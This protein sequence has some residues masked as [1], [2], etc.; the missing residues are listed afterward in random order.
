[1]RR[2]LIVLMLLMCVRGIALSDDSRIGVVTLNTANANVSFSNTNEYEWR[3]ES[4]VNA[5]FSTNYHQD[6][7]TSQTTITITNDKLCTL[8]FEYG[9][10]SEYYY[11]YLVITLDGAIIV[12]KSG[13]VIDSYSGVLSAGTHDLEL[14]YVKDVN[15]YDNNDL[16]Y[17]TDLKIDNDLKDLSGVFWS[18]DESEG[19]L[20]ISG[21]GEM[22]DYPLW[23]DE[24]QP[25]ATYASQI[26][27]IVIGEGITRIGKCCFNGYSNVESV[28]LPST[29]LSIGF[30]A[31]KECGIK[32]ITIPSSVSEIDDEAFTYCTDMTDIYISGSFIQFG[33]RAF[34]R[35]Y[36]LNVHIED[37]S[38]WCNLSFSDAEANP[39][40]TVRSKKL[41]TNYTPKLY[42]NETVVSDLQ[43]PSS[44]TEI[45]DFTFASYQG[46]S[47]IVIPE[48]VTAI[49]MNSFY[50]CGNSLTS[51]VIEPGNPNYDSRDN[52]NAIIRKSDNMLLQGCR[53]TTIPEGIVGIATNA[54]YACSGL[55]SIQIPNTVV[56]I[57]EKAFYRATGLTSIELPNSIT[58]IGRYAFDFCDNLRS[59]TLS[60]NLSQV[61]QG[62]F[63]DCTNLELVNIP[64]GVKY[65]SRYEFSYCQ[66]MVSIHIPSS[67]ETIDRYAF[68][69]CIGLETITC[70][71]ETPPVVYDDTF[72]GV[73]CS[74]VTLY[75]PYNSIDLYR[76][77]DVWKDFRIEVLGRKVTIDDVLYL[78][79][80]DKTAT[81]IAGTSKD[82]IKIPDHIV[83]DGEDY[84]V[85]AIG[86]Q[87]FYTVENVSRIVLPST[88]TS[89]GSFALYNYEVS[90][91]YCNAVTP[92]ALSGANSISD[93]TSVYVPV[94][95]KPS[96]RNAPYWKDHQKLYVM[97]DRHDFGDVAWEWDGTESATAILVCKNDAEEVFRAEADITSA[98]II[99]ST[100]MSKGVRKLTAKAVFEDLEGA[101]EYQTEKEVDIPLAEHTMIVVDNHD[102]THSSICS[103]CNGN[104]HRETH[105]YTDG[106]CKAC[107]AVS[108]FSDTDLSALSNVVYAAKVSVS[109]G[110]AAVVPIGMNN[111][112]PMTGFQ[113]QISVPFADLS[114]AVVS[115][116][117]AN[118]NISFRSALQSDGTIRV[119][120]Y[121]TDGE[122]LEGADG[123]IM[124]I[125]A[126]P[127]S[128]QLELKD[129]PVT[130]SG[131]RL[132]Q[133]GTLYKTDTQVK[134]TLT[135]VPSIKTGDANGDG[136]VNVGD[137]SAVVSHILGYNPKVFDAEAAD[138]NND[139]NINVGDITT[140]ANMILSNN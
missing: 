123:G 41:N 118:R 45:K 43:I 36:N 38:A 44:V 3:W 74:R 126:F 107:G 76:A 105:L 52:C 138:A 20:T 112:V 131:I 31:F 71:C 117:C 99:P 4:G 73:N 51:I 127:V 114:E 24:K 21:S 9:V 47:S 109:S 133:S 128:E 79:C 75:V 32:S 39:L 42:L 14:K 88:I 129:Y 93:L 7:T 70:D 60:N 106:Y 34:E 68:E 130:I 8:S 22:S 102:G 85:N 19:E 54:F 86:S 30:R 49:G 80:H 104:E 122:Y 2:F 10:S 15:A 56:G 108:D 40:Y 5:L 46:L 101:P 96:Y 94:G 63:S 83:V 134:S 97:E 11:D 58:E 111:T 92:P 16:S 26:R 103:V 50:D 17:I 35:C 77:A 121:T 29:L 90:E 137:I 98:D 33:L 87:A 119:L 62:L 115:Y 1:M 12:K 69:D 48:S 132:T 135:V 25:W 6:G 120:C 95:T 100:C 82:L 65:L 66:S 81:V 61:G 23:G 13:Y 53:N 110:K 72:I 116:S 84:S 37:L 27:S 18:F 28:E 64:L 91:V 78:A 136:N 140:I 89:I 139:G 124:C 55:Q 125:I 59:V 57:G 67:I 113:F